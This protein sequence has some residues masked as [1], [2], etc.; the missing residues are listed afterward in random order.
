MSIIKEIANSLRPKDPIT[1]AIAEA[2]AEVDATHLE[3]EQIEMLADYMKEMIDGA[4]KRGQTLAPEEAALMA[5]EDVEG[6]ETA[7]Q[8]ILKATA[9][10][11]VRSYHDQFGK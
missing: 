3:D 5:L 4:A 8:K 7:P 2:M 11:L 6:F 1:S 10:R 9:A